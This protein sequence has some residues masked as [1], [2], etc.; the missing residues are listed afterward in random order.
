M[1]VLQLYLTSDHKTFQ[2]CA[3]KSRLQEVI[4]E[5]QANFLSWWKVLHNDPQER[6]EHEGLPVPVRKKHTHTQA[7]LMRD[8]F[9]ERT[10]YGKEYEVTAHTFLDSHKAERDIN[11]WLL[12][13]ADPVGQSLN[14]GLILII[15]LLL[16]LSQSGAI[17][18]T[19]II[20]QWKG[21][22]G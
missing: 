16:L 5:H 21:L 4:M 1:C 11:H 14:K 17:T 7:A 18:T 2:K 6:L 19:I 22:L 10:P 13:T 8:L 20:V 15:L 9:L 3:K 12:L